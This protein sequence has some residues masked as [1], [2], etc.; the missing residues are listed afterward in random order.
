MKK[1]CIVENGLLEQ[2]AGSKARRDVADIL[3]GLGWEACPVH[4]IKVRVNVSYLERIRM[5]LVFQKDWKRVEKTIQSGDELL[6]QYP[7][8]MYPKVSMLAL[9]QIQ[10]LK[11][12]NVR[13][14]ML[15]H[16]LD[17]LRNQN[18]EERAWYQGAEEKFLS[19]ADYIIAHNKKMTAYLKSCKMTQPI[20]SLGLFDYLVD[21]QMSAAEKKNSAEGIVIAGNLAPEKAGYVYQLGSVDARFQLYGPNVQEEKL[22]KNMDYKG[23]FPPD[24]LPEILEG[25]FGLVWDGDSLNG[26]GGEFGEYV[27]YNNPH[28]ASL[29]LA[30]G[31]PVI[32]WKEAAVADFV[33]KYQVGIT[34]NSLEEI[35]GEMANMTEEKYQVLK[36]KVSE[37]AEKLRTGEMLKETME[38]VGR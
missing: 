13:I 17:S 1:Y 14:G 23:S 24:K 36:G 34:V 27:K 3:I 37:I 30:C 10:K 29:Y 2:H 11:Q 38:K 22:G 18:P 26:C 32:V 20:Y 4:P 28:K 5:A 31:L 25:K 15:I 33:E 12:K 16:D 35:S 6:I 19:Q 8:D 21:S 9:R 7:L